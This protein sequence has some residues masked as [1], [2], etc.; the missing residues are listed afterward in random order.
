MKINPFAY[1][2]VVLLV[3]LGIIIGFQQVG[4]WSTSGKVNPSGQQIQPAAGDV[5]TIKGWMTLEQVSTTFGV[6]VAEILSA[7]NLP[8]DTPPATALKNLE[9]DSFDIPSLRIW[10][11]ERQPPIP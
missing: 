7:F 4:V 11:Q 2:I 6:S 3:F 5:N 10:L 8:A 1:G 9:N